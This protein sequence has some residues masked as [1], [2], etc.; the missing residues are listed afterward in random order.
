M[1]AGTPADA[2]PRFPSP[3][4][5]PDVPISGIRL[6]DGVHHRLTN[7]HNPASADE[8]L[9]VRRTPAPERTGA[10]PARP[11]C[12]AFSESD[13]LA[14]PRVHPRLDTPRCRNPG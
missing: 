10:C 5:K 3:L 11:P 12:A 1:G 14:L 4:I 8:T 7:P 13:A 2:T 9:R 6:S